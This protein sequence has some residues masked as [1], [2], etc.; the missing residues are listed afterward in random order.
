MGEKFLVLQTTK[1]PVL[2]G[3]DEELVN[4]SRPKRRRWRPS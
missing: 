1:F 4:P 2:K 3:E